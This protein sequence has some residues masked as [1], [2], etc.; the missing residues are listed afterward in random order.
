METVKRTWH[1]LAYTWYSRI[2]RVRPVES[3]GVRFGGAPRLSTPVLN[4]PDDECDNA[5]LHRKLDQAYLPIRYC[6]DP[7]DIYLA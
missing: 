5:R 3:N 6:G 2:G 4:A 1:W 7:R